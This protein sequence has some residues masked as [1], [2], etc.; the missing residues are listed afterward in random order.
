MEGEQIE[1]VLKNRVGD[2]DRYLAMFDDFE[3]TCMKDWPQGMVFTVGLA[4]S[5]MSAMKQYIEEHGDQLQTE[6]T[7]AKRAAAG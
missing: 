6:A 1:T 2:I 4:R 5:V 3:R 7:A